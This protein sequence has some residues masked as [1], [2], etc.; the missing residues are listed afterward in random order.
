MLVKLLDYKGA[1]A[2]I[3]PVHVRL[4]RPA[5]R[6]TEIVLGTRPSMSGFW[7]LKVRGSPEEVAYV[8]NAGMPADGYIP[9]DEGHAGGHATAFVP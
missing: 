2:W 7:T 5:G 8:L 4:V 3:N 1:E 9:D 6:F